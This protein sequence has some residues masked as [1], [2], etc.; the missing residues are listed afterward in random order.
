MT[1]RKEEILLLHLSRENACYRPE[2]KCKS[3]IVCLLTLYI[4]VQVLSTR[5][6]KGN[7]SE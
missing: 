1:Q 3:G 5:N 4:H 7:G 6:A 2:Y